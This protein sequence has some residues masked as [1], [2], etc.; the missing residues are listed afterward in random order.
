MRKHR[1]TVTSYGCAQP[2]EDGTLGSIWL[3]KCVTCQEWLSLGPANDTDEAFA[4]E[5]RLADRLAQHQHQLEPSPERDEADDAVIWMALL[6]LEWLTWKPLS[7]FA[8]STEGTWRAQ[9]QPAT[10]EG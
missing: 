4:P 8:R 9:Y 7:E 5:V 6:E 3:S 1:H 2:R 10:G